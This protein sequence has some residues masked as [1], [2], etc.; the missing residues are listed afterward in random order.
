MSETFLRIFWDNFI[1]LDL[2]AH[3]DVSSEQSS[4]PVTN[5]YNTQRRSKVWRSNGYFN[6]TASN[7]QIVLRETNGG[8]DLIAQITIAEYSSVTSMCAA[9]KS[10]LEAIGASTYTVTN[11]SSTGFKFQIVSNGSGGSGVF[12]LMLTD[13]DFTAASILGFDDS[14]DL[15]DSSL[16][17]LSDFLTISSEEFIE[18]DLGISSNPTGFAL[19]GPRNSPLKL[20]PGGTY[21]LQANYTSNWSMPAYETDLA[22]ND[23]ALFITNEDGIADDSY[24]FWRVQIVDQNPN[25]Y[26]EVGFIGLG[27]FFTPVRGR[28]Q[29]GMSI[30]LVDLTQTLF[31]EGGQSYADIKPKTANYSI[32]WVGLKKEAIEE[33]E[34]QFAI[35]GTGIPFLV[36]LDTFPAFSSSAQ[37]RV[38]FAKFAQEPRFTLISPNNFECSMILREEL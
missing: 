7:N 36:G 25:G 26:V 31:S 16:T 12:H 1:D 13:S 10:A 14:I 15:T 33:I 28:P 17:R 20:S 27:N 23:N 38:L 11:S 24:R 34:D 30:D 18:W 8:P 3:S 2:L 32:N 29:Y 35:Y 22:Y 19:I 9:I 5:A 37:R 4:F 21:K 6:I